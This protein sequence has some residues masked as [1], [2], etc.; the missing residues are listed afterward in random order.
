M[1][2]AT[3]GVGRYRSNIEFRRRWLTTADVAVCVLLVGY[4]TVSRALTYGG[5]D[6]DA[7]IGQLREVTR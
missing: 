7:L 1:V 4:G 5:V 3:P 2:T 6:R